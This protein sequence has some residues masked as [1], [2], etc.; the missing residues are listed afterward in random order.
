MQI[1]DWKTSKLRNL[2]QKNIIMFNEENDSRYF[3]DDE[4]EYMLN[5]L[6]YSAKN[7]T[8]IDILR[9]MFNKSLGTL[10]KIMEELSISYLFDRISNKILDITPENTMKLLVRCK[11]MLQ[12][13]TQLIKI[14]QIID[15]RELKLKELNYYVI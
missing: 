1:I 2:T 3:R 12:C 10:E 9:P 8:T 7:F 5:M 14:L 4:I 15:A 13:R 11:L 6:K